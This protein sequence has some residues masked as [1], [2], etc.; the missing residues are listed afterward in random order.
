MYF[1]LDI[2]CVLIIVGMMIRFWS[3][4]LSSVLL[5]G[6]CVLLGILIAVFATAPLAEVTGAVLVQ[7]V[8]ERSAAN[9]LADMVSGAHR[10]TGRET[11]ERLDLTQL[12]KD[13]PPAF[14]EWVERYH[15]DPATAVAAYNRQHSGEALLLAVTGGYCTALS[16]SGSFAVL[17]VVSVLLLLLIARRIELN[18]APPTRRTMG[19]KIGSPL[20]G[21]LTGVLIVMGLTVMLEWLVP[22]VRGQMLLFASD[23]LT[24]GTVYPILKAVN[25][26]LWVLS[27][28]G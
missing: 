11:A 10:A 21:A 9:D 5:R 24:A 7:P 17:W 12:I 16:K 2:I 18:M 27:L 14:I 3:S 25:P 23:M 15:A 22:F 28:I 19:T 4:A 26:F 8:V 6:L 13:Q 1:V 20:L